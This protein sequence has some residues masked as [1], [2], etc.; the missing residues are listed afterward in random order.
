MPHPVHHSFSLFS[1]CYLRLPLSSPMG[2]FDVPTKIRFQIGFTDTLEKRSRRNRRPGWIHPKTLQWRIWRPG[3]VRGL[4]VRSGM[5][6]KLIPHPI[7]VAFSQGW[8]HCKQKNV[9]MVTNV[10]NCCFLNLWGNDTGSHCLARSFSDIFIDLVLCFVFFFS[11]YVLY[12]LL[13]INAFVILW[14]HGLHFK[15]IGLR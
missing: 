1:I 2:M 6:Q 8:T 7:F 11:W 9:R 3:Q 4:L 14:N 12:S 13:Q 15:T 10:L 5:Y